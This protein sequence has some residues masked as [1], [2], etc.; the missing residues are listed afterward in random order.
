[1]PDRG[2][3]LWTS[4]QAFLKASLKMFDGG[5]EA[6]V[7]I[8]SAETQPP[9]TKAPGYSYRNRNPAVIS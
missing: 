6:E 4:Q 3:E 9:D 1:M 8:C 7:R 2:V 5:E